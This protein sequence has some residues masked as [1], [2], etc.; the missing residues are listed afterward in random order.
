MK[1]Y[2]IGMKI[3]MKLYEKN[4]NFLK[5]FFKSDSL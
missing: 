3:N 2:E 1:L 5:T 4:Y